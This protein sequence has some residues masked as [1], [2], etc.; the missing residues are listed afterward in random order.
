MVISVVVPLYNEE[1]GLREFYQCLNEVLRNLPCDSEIWFVD[2]GSADS[3]ASIVRG[4]ME[5]DPHV[6]LI[7]LTRNFGHQTALTAGLDFADGDAIICMDGDGQHPPD[8]I[9]HMVALYERG[10]DVVL[11]QRSSSDERMFKHWTSRTF[12]A[13]INWL[14]DT[15]VLEASA[16]FRLVSRQVVLELRRTREYHRFLRG[17]ISWMGFRHTVRSFN[18]PPRIGGRSRYS[19]GKMF[20][21]AMN[22]IFSFST[23]PLQISLL[24][25]A[26]FLLLAVAQLGYTLVLVLSGQLEN[27][28]PGWVSLIFSVLGAA[29]VQLI[30]L[31]VIGNYVGMIFQEVKRRPLYLLQAAPMYPADRDREARNAETDDKQRATYARG[32]Y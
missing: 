23:V 8:L 21:L 16:D 3:T 4:L 10:F 15:P 14:S 13:L 26:V 29:G 17:L 31:G 28:S 19:A 25:G 2:D 9:P 11:T 20:R 32:S 5:K 30:V 12:Y 1:A 18:P 6:G 7:Q 27:W 24:L 22:A